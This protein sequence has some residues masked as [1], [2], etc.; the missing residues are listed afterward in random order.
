MSGGDVGN[1]H[2]TLSRQAM[3]SAKWK[4]WQKKKKGNNQPEVWQCEWWQGGNCC[5]SR[6]QCKM[7]VVAK[8]QKRG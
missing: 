3:G 1:C 8:K 7:E 2:V 6:G 4:W 5:A